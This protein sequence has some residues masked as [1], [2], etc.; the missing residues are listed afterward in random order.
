MS[1]VETRPVPINILEW[2]RI[3]DLIMQQK[4]IYSELYYNPNASSC[5]CYLY[6]VEASA[7]R[8]GMTANSLDDALQE[9]ERRRLVNGDL[10]L[11]QFS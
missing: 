1:G 7:A 5:G 10:K 8:L 4:F 11:I 6:G 9:F 2:P 3:R